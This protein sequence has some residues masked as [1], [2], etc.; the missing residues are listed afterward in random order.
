MR[1]TKQHKPEISE[2][3]P[4]CMRC[5]YIR[6]FLV[7]LMALVIFALAAGDDVKLLAMITPERVAAAI[8]IGGS[9]SFAVKYY[10][11]RRE[12]AAANKQPSD[13]A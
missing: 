13:Q 10:F 11:Y 12:L 1:P 2:A 6:Y 9:I 5:L 3:D 8:M 7:T 4:P